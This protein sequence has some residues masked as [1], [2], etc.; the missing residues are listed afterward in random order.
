MKLNLGMNC[1]AGCQGGIPSLPLANSVT[2]GKSPNSLCLGFLV[3]IMGGMMTL[4]LYLL[5]RLH[6]L[7]HRRHLQ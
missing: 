7:I 5:G 4:L 6:E 1:V 3:Y 2:L